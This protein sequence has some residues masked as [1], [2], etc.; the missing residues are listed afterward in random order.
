MKGISGPAL[1]MKS[2]WCINSLNMYM[3]ITWERTCPIA[4]HIDSG[5]SYGSPARSIWKNIKRRHTKSLKSH[6]DGLSL[7]MHGHSWEVAEFELACFNRSRIV[8]AHAADFVWERSVWNNVR[9][10]QDVVPT[11][12][13]KGI[14]PELLNSFPHL[15]GYHFTSPTDNFIFHS[16]LSLQALLPS[17]PCQNRKWLASHVTANKMISKLC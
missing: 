17:W 6:I 16:W 4:C 15:V 9:G 2:E 13:V 1:F 7:R 3:Y 12:T 14:V 5:V 10:N 11:Y 8:S